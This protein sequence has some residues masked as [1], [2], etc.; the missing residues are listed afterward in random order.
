MT[1]QRLDRGQSK[2]VGLVNVGFILRAAWRAA[3]R[4]GAALGAR[5]GQPDCSTYQPGVEG[6]AVAIAPELESAEFGRSLHEGLS[7]GRLGGSES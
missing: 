2:P 3:A 1:I 7:L 6:V 4:Q 5:A